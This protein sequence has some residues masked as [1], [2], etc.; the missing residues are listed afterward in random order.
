MQFLVPFTLLKK[1]KF[2]SDISVAQLMSKDNVKRFISDDQ[3]FPSFRNIRET[4]QYFHNMLLDI[5]AKTRQFGVY[6]FFLICSAAECHWTEIIQI[7][8][9]QYGGTRTDDKVNSMDWG[10]KMNY[11]KR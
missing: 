7:V 6:S 10:T 11:L 9:R 5:L 2:Q 4:P 1:K 3:I 8:T